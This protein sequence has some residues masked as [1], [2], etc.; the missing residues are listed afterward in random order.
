MISIGS[1]KTAGLQHK[2][3]NWAMKKKNKF[4][5]VIVEHGKVTVPSLSH[6]HNATKRTVQR[7]G[8]HLCYFMLSI[9]TVK[10]SNIP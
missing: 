1:F 4:Q 10:L 5:H 2:V 9:V 3:F 6:Y 7:H 8:L